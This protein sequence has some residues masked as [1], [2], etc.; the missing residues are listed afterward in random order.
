MRSTL[1]PRCA[2][3]FH[4]LVLAALA[5]LW[6]GI[7]S[8]HAQSLYVPRGVAA[9]YEKGT[10]S[11]DGRPGPRYWQNRA[12]Y[13]ITLTTSPPNRAV[14]GTEQ[15]VYV[16]NSPDTLSRLAMR[17][18][19]N[20]HKPGA[21]RAGE[22]SQNYLTSGVHI[23]KFAA[24]GQPVKWDAESGFTVQRV[25]LPTPL[26]PHDSLRLSVDWHYDMSKESGREG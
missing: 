24:N 22:A 16:N 9:A 25:D 23:D 13:T 26:L 1:A 15:I 17:L 6:L 7:S 5:P 18:I 8:A 12:R 3:P 14:A 11:R 10:R 19:V 21:P 20:I 2:H 4:F